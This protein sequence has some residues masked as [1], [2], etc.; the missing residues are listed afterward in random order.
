[1]LKGIGLCFFRP[2]GSREFKNEVDNIWSLLILR[3]Y[4]L[5]KIFLNVHAIHI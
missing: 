4:D 3:N 1:M 2:P 5:D